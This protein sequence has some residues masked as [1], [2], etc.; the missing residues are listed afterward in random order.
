VWR[1]I[2]M[3]DDKCNCE[4]CF[5]CRGECCRSVAIELEE[6]EDLNEFEDLKWY[7]FHTGITVYIDKDGDWYVDVPIKCKHLDDEGKCMI[8]ETRPPVCRDYDV[9]D[10]DNAEDE[11]TEFETPQDVDDYV[12]KLKAE[13]RFDDKGNL[14]KEEKPKQENPTN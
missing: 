12:A 11:E 8:Y 13:G 6:P 1:D 14:K 9:D 2:G 5:E 7:L 10:C 4:K 3:S